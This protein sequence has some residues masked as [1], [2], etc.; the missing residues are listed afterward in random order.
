MEARV[1]SV[2]LVQ[3]LPHGKL[4]SHQAPGRA[5]RP[6]TGRPPPLRFLDIR[7]NHTE[8]SE[9]MKKVDSCEHLKTGCTD[10]E[11]RETSIPPSPRAPRPRE[12]ERMGVLSLGFMDIRGI[13]RKWKEQKRTNQ[14]NRKLKEKKGNG[15]SAKKTGHRKPT[16]NRKST[17][18]RRKGGPPEVTQ[19]RRIKNRKRTNR[20]IENPKKNRKSTQKEGSPEVTQDQRTKTRKAA[21]PS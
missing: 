4:R 19:D 6:I 16:K 12:R 5:G 17:K 1:N 8:S 18:K 10:R 3:T 7:G 21:G 14:K 11:S 9:F 20:K 15:K 2:G 13:W